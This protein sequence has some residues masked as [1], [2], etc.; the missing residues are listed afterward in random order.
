MRVVVLVAAGIFFAGM[1]IYA[2]AAPAAL[3]RPFRLTPDA[4]ES[5]SE[6]RAVYG[7]FGLAV[8]GVL[9]WAASGTDDLRSGAALTVGVALAG[10]AA[11]RVISRVL[12]AGTAFYPIW[13]YCL[14]EVVGAALVLAVA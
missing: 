14:V 2:L 7:G 9:W 5:R 12:D 3:V 8:A 10:M 4:A 11:G 6:V 13:F 1:G